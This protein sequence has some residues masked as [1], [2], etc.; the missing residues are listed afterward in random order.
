MTKIIKPT[1]KAHKEGGLA[2]IGA[3]VYIEVKVKK[4]KCAI[5]S[6]KSWNKDRLTIQLAVKDEVKG[7]RWA[8]LKHNCQTV[9]EAK[10]YVKQILNN[11]PD[12]YQLH[13]FEE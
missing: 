8:F 7:W 2:S 1:F 13:F 12:K 9:D 4:R 11:L 3:G 5:I 6:G 10:E